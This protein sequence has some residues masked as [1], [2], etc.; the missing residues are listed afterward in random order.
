VLFTI[1]VLSACSGGSGPAVAPTTDVILVRHAD[2]DGELINEKGQIRARALRDLVY[3][4]FGPVDAV[5]HTTFERTAQTLQPIVERAASEGR[6]VSEYAL[7]PHDYGAFADR[8]REEH[9]KG[10]PESV[11]VFAGHSNNIRPIL[12]LFNKAGTGAHEAEWFPCDAGICKPDYDDYWTI[13]LRGSETP[14]ITKFTYGAATPADAG[15]LE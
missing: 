4:E 8:I 2:R 9:A 1:L 12:E 6:P 15:E 11:L 10:R 14:R 7:E 5:L 3:N 13:T